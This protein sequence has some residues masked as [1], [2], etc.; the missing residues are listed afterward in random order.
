[1]RF[2]HIHLIAASAELPAKAGDYRF[3][4]RARILMIGFCLD[5]GPVH[6]ADLSARHNLPELLSR[7][8]ADA[9][10]TKVAHGASGTRSLIS[11][12]LKLSCPPD[13][14]RCTEVVARTLGLPAE[15]EMCC[16]FLGIDPTPL[17][18]RA[19]LQQKFCRPQPPGARKLWLGR[20]D[21][22]D[23]WEALATCCQE[24]TRKTKELF[25]TL[26]RHDL[27]RAEWHLWAL[28]QRIN[29]G[30]VRVDQTLV[31]NAIA[32][33]G[34]RQ[35]KLIAEAVRLTG[36]ANPNSIEQLRRWLER[37]SHEKIDSLRKKDM[38]ILLE[39]LQGGSKRALQ[40]RQELSR[41]SVQKYHV[42]QR[43][44][45]RDGRLRGMLQFHGAARTGR[46]AG[47]LVQVQNLPKNTMADLDRLREAVIANDA[48]LL[49]LLFDD[50]GSVLSELL[51]T[52]IVA[53]P[54][55]NLVICDFA[56]IEARV[57]AW[58]AQE[59]WRLDLFRGSGRLYEASASKMFQV[60]DDRIVP[61]NPEYGLRQKGKIAELALGYQGGPR[62]LMA[63]G[64]LD[65]GIPE[66]ELA[67]IVSAWRV[68]NPNIVT[69][70]QQLEAE[71]IAAVEHY[72]NNG[73]F[74]MDDGYLF[75]H[76]PSGRR[77][78]Y[79]RARLINGPYGPKLQY[80]GKDAKTHQWGWLAT[81][82]GKLAENWTQAVARDVL[83]EALLALDA[84]NLGPILFHIHDEVV[85]ET[86]ADVGKIETLMSRP[87]KWAPDLPLAAKGFVAQYFRK[88]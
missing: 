68:A 27:P 61:G 50:V 36:L 4:E 85:L 72:S 82:G 78:A 77:L 46:W 9:K 81:Y 60:P 21:A 70:W 88:E 39:K 10:I 45:C 67:G 71:A 24:V 55:K 75:M 76:L 74:K 1:M 7:A 33:S 34:Q 13:H 47:R 23:E 44:L 14:W 35:E 84:A 42:I 6:V 58:G 29:D 54:G 52:T 87:P 73:R 63:M 17:R 43:C 22:P 51:R 18:A 8:L 2:L 53:E 25:W 69:F 12:C 86:A 79:P 66:S 5:T 3:A 59:T 31:K 57:L 49:E 62:A 40:I 15:L 65:M 26:R 11:N 38:P 30:G 48:E 32:I 28:D 16:Q 41:T 37:E 19:A 56:S 83:A 64:A 20:N 80:W